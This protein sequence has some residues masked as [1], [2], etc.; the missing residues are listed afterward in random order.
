MLPFAV[1]QFRSE[2]AKYAS[3][4]QSSKTIYANNLFFTQ[5]AS[6]VTRLMDPAEALPAP[7][8]RQFDEEPPSL[9]GARRNAFNELDTQLTRMVREAGLREQPSMACLRWGFNQR[10]LQNPALSYDEA[11]QLL[12]MAPAP[13]DACLI[14]EL[15]RERME[16]GKAAE[17]CQQLA[18]R[19][20]EQA[21][22]LIKLRK[23]LMASTSAALTSMRKFTLLHP[24]E[25]H[26]YTESLARGG[27]GGGSAAA[28]FRSRDRQ[29]FNQS[30]REQ[31]WLI[32]DFGGESEYAIPLNHERITHLKRDYERATGPVAAA[33]E[34]GGSSGSGDMRGDQTFLRR[35]WSM[36]ARYDTISGA[37]Y[38]AALPEEG[39]G[40]LQR[41]W[42]VEHECYASP[43]NHCL[44]SFGSAFID[45]D[46]FFGSKGREHARGH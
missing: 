24:S 33:A 10:S 15:Q 21:E 16:A 28:S 37:G 29:T 41:Y 23:R 36:C 13:T 5:D 30:A 43:L 27:G 45:T 8:S 9:I 11:D 19:C 39:F 40:M 26:Q 14:M 1:G 4:L 42:G 46:R 22:K 38:Q 6:L 12:P 18:A 7:P 25:A 32:Y 44:D 3:I 31:Y 34:T 2:P 20:K 35:L 17:I